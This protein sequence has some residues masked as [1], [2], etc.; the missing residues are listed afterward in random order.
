MTKKI[1]ILCVDDEQLILN[2]LSSVFRFKYN[3]ITTTN[4]QEA[5]N[6]IESQDI[7]VIISDQRMPEM[8]GTELLK[9]VKEKSPNTIR[10]L[11][12]GFSDIDAIISTVND[13]EVYRF[14]TKP[15]NNEELSSIVADAVIASNALKE[16]SNTL[17][18]SDNHLDGLHSIIEQYGKKIDDQLSVIEEETTQSPSFVVF[19]C[20]DSA[21]LNTLKEELPDHVNVL[22]ASNDHEVVELLS[23]HP[24]K[25]LLSY[26]DI[27][28][29]DNVDLLKS[30]KR[31][32]PE[33]LS[34]AVVKYADYE[35]I[36]TLINEA[37][38][39]R[40]VVMPLKGGQLAR[41]IDSGLRMFDRLQKNP[42]LLK[43]QNVV[44]KSNQTTNKSFVG[45]LKSFFR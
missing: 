39:Y 25:I 18:A 44:I 9:I 5:L 38:V 24:V 36:I 12:T 13:S 20:A 40:Y 42:S 19:H 23:Q 7:S 35:E 33:L 16:G 11:L 43:A 6:I 3:V 8:M 28:S 17:T 29:G 32:L 1:N 27:A 21:V 45:K 4:P 37:K 10:I 2:A 31:E 34:I 22:Y 41:Y 30:L 15:W 26:L 14:L